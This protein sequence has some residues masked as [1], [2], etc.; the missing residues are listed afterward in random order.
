MLYGRLFPGIPVTDFAL[1]TGRS[2]PNAPRPAV[3]DP[4]TGLK[5]RSGGF[6]WVPENH[7]DFVS[8]ILHAL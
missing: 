6:A 5:S 3:E 8:V 1:R 2:G 4:V 7:G